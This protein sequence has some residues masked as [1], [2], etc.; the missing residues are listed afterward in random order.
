MLYMLQYQLY[1]FGFL[2]FYLG[3]LNHFLHFSEDAL[4]RGLCFANSGDLLSPQINDL[5]YILLTVTTLT[6]NYCLIKCMVI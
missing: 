2:Y 4:E 5:N 6:G 1:A 3:L